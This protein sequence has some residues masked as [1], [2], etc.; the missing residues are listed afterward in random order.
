MHMPYEICTFTREYDIPGDE[1]FEVE[2]SVR[3]DCGLGTQN[4]RMYNSDGSWADPPD[5]N[6]ADICESTIREI[7]TNREVNL[8]LTLVERT[9]LEEQALESLR[10]WREPY[11][12]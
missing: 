1:W 6:Y 4:P 9:Y 5:P 7:S 8:E 11:Y 2:F 10:D 3:V 12:A